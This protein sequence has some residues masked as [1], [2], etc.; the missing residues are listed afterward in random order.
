MKKEDFIPRIIDPKPDKYL[1]AFGAVCVEGP[2][3]CGKT[4]TSAHHSRSEIFIGTRSGISRT[5]SWRRVAGSGTGRRSAAEGLL[6][7]RKEFSEDPKGHPP[8]VLC[9]ICGL[10]KAAYRRPD[11]VFVVPITALKN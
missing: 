3:W 6:K 7:L 2:K 1:S 8:D 5:A 9:V 4:W 10:S 11:G